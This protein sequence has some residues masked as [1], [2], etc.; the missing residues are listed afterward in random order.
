MLGFVP[1]GG[2]D[3]HW[4]AQVLVLPRHPRLSFSR[5]VRPLV[6]LVILVK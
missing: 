2:A 4:Q 3:C 6:A 1:Q 5:C